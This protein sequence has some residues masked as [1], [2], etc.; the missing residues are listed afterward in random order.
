[1]NECDVLLLKI[2]YCY[3]MEL[4]ATD[5]KIKQFYSNAGDG[6]RMKLAK[7]PLSEKTG[8]PIP[9]SEKI[10]INEVLTKE[11]IETLLTEVNFNS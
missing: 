9:D 10:R 8:K 5:E 3:Q 7:I 6:Y 11:E 2:N 1:M 4:A